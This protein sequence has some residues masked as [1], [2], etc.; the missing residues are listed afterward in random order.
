MNLL[1][2]MYQMLSDGKRSYKFFWKEENQ[3]YEFGKNKA[4]TPILAF[5]FFLKTIEKKRNSEKEELRFYYSG[6]TTELWES[7]PGS[8]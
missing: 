8:L 5:P 7:Y 6:M 3:E 1:S 2:E 4:D